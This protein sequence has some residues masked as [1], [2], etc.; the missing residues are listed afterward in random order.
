MQNFESGMQT[1]PHLVVEV[2]LNEHFDFTP[3]VNPDEVNGELTVVR[4]EDKKAIS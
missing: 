1:S 3:D 2:K 4:P